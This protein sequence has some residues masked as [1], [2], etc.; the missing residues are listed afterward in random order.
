[1]PRNAY[2]KIRHK[3]R[4]KARLRRRKLERLSRPTART[5]AWFP[6]ATPTAPIDDAILD[7]QRAL[8]QEI[9]DAE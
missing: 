3:R 1:M 9:D 8:L 7:A 2:Q 4:E 6:P 5:R